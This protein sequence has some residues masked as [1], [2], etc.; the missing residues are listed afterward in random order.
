MRP[1]WQTVRWLRGVRDDWNCAEYFF[2]FLTHAYILFSM[3]TVHRSIGF[4]HTG[5]LA[6]SAGMTQPD[7]GGNYNLGITFTYEPKQNADGDWEDQPNIDMIKEH[8]FKP[9]HVLW[10]SNPSQKRIVISVG[11]GVTH[12]VV[13]ARDPGQLHGKVYTS[14][15]NTFGQLGQGDDRKETSR[16]ALT[17]VRNE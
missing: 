10:Q 8:Y 13:A 4:G 11:V 14:G 1:F 2:F 7:A 9:K 3:W 5:E 15:M 12:L 6:R 16:H 17:L